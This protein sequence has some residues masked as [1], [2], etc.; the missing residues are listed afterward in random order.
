MLSFIFKCK[1]DFTDKKPL[2]KIGHIIFD[3]FEKT[4]RFP[5]SM[6]VTNVKTLE[7][8]V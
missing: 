2:Y 1:V 5:P 7:L 8:S 4:V 3:Y 6:S